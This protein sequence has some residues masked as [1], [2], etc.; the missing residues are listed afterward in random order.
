MFEQK[1]ENFQN[2]YIKKCAKKWGED[3]INSL[4][5]IFISTVQ[6]NNVSLKITKL[7]NLISSLFLS[8]FSQIFT[9]LF[10][11]FTLSIDLT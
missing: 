5:C 2:F 4:I 1:R 3:I 8:D 6:E 7:H 9:V 10:E 11:I